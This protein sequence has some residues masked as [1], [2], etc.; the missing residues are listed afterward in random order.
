MLI[1]GEKRLSQITVCLEAAPAF[2]LSAEAATAIVAH[3]I[4]VIRDNWDQ[5][6]EEAVLSVVDRHLMW[7][8]Q[9]LNPFVLE[10]ASARLREIAGED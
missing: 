4:T 3:Q 5:V 6:C 9:I 1:T 8:R 7:R 10:G 2:Q